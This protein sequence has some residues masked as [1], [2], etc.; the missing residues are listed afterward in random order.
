MS[1]IKSSETKV[2]LMI[3]KKQTYGY[4]GEKQR[5]VVLGKQKFDDEVVDPELLEEAGPGHLIMK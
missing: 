5:I 2:L 4:P 1:I 3:L